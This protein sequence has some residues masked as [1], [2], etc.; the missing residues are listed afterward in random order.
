MAKSVS[1]LTMC[2]FQPPRNLKLFLREWNS[3]PS[4]ICTYAVLKPVFWLAENCNRHFYIPR[5]SISKKNVVCT[6]PFELD[7]LKDKLHFCPSGLLILPDGCC[8]YFLLLHFYWHILSCALL[9][10]KFVS[11]LWDK[12]SKIPFSSCSKVF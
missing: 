6:W 11:A 2:W 12:W 7:P 8:C 4:C 1:Y 9:N 10:M 3:R 5:I